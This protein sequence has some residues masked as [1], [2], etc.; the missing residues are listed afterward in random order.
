[1]L[2]TLDHCNGPVLF[3]FFLCLRSSKRY[4]SIRQQTE[5]GVQLAPLSFCCFKC[6]SIY[7]F[8]SYFGRGVL[9]IH[10]NNSDAPHLDYPFPSCSFCGNVGS[11]RL[12][13]AGTLNGAL[14]TAGYEASCCNPYHT[15]ETESPVPPPLRSASTSFIKGY[16]KSTVTSSSTVFSTMVQV[17][18]ASAA[19][20][21]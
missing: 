18:I 10:H 20:A 15:T 13:P 7:L 16:S 5:K 9:I 1:M 19:A 2:F 8:F 21:L 6:H 12:S 14:P 11:P 3:I 17:A 4:F